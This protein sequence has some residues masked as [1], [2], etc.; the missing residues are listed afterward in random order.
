MTPC[1]ICGGQGV[2][3]AGNCVRCGIYRGVD[4]DS[5]ARRRP[6]A[7]VLVIAVGVIAL[8]LV[9]GAVV[10]L[11]TRLASQLPASA[12]RDEPTERDEPAGPVEASAPVVPAVE[13]TATAPPQSAKELAACIVGKWREKSKVASMA[14]GGVPGQ[15]GT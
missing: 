7:A 9:G 12:E 1:E 5:R 13:P 8:L 2:D 15:V 4:V 10:V 3:K 14:I 6:G 11:I